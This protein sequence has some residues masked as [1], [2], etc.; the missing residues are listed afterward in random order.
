MHKAL[1][2]VLALAFPFSA[3]AYSFDDV[4]HYTDE[5]FRLDV[6]SYLDQQVTRQTN[7]DFQNSLQNAEQKSRSQVQNILDTYRVQQTGHLLDLDIQQM[8]QQIEQSKE[9]SKRLDDQID[10]INVLLSQQQSSIA[11]QKKL[12]D[13]QQVYANTN[14]FCKSLEPQYRDTGTT[15]E[16]SEGCAKYG[17]FIPTREE[18]AARN[19]T[20]EDQQSDPQE[21]ASG[22]L[23]NDFI[24]AFENSGSEAGRGVGRTLKEVFLSS[25]Q[26]TKKMPSTQ[27]PQIKEAVDVLDDNATD[28]PS[29]A[30]PKDSTVFQSVW[31]T[32]TSWL[33][34]LRWL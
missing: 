7:Q 14:A 5:Q 11:E 32:V 15:K 12:D 4:G 10:Q 19:A 16:L 30:V 28:T 21:D 2:F 20:T 27:Q 1:L 8:Q 25:D 34:H 22:N 3:M 9:N 31:R 18:V 24:T 33:S 17:V 26:P 6:K 23:E 13:E 29:N